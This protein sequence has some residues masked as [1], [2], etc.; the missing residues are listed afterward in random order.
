[1]G[2]KPQLSEAAGRRAVREVLAMAPGYWKSLP[3]IV[4]GVGELTQT[5]AGNE[6]VR[7]WIEWN[8]AR[9][10]VAHRINEDSDEHEWN[11]TAHGLAKEAVK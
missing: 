1:M 3:V 6:E 7:G 9:D 4:R 11:I 5:P 10:Y 8:I 2:A